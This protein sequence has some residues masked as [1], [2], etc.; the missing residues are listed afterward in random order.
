MSEQD[1]LRQQLF[2]ALDTVEAVAKRLTGDECPD[3]RAV[4]S[5]IV[6]GVNVLRRTIGTIPEPQARTR[7]DAAM[8]S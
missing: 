5:A 1:A 4:S 8:R 7:A 3:A 2:D 6:D